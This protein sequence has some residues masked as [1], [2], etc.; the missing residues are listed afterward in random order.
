MKHGVK[1]ASSRLV[2]HLLELEAISILTRVLQ[3]GVRSRT[4]GFESGQSIIC[5]ANWGFSAGESQL[6]VLV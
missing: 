2:S 4:V 6:G 1:L 3:D 5:I